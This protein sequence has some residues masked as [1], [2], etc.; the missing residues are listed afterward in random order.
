GIRDKLVTG[1]QTCALPILRTSMGGMPAKVSFPGRQIPGL[2]LDLQ[3]PEEF[4]LRDIDFGNGGQAS[5]RQITLPAKGRR[6]V[7]ELFDARSE[8][9]RV[10]KEGRGRWSA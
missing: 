9:R 8:E 10:G 3:L 2:Q 7:L 6:Q 1:V 4:R 5:G